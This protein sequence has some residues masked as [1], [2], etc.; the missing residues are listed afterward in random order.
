MEV[1]Q[2]QRQCP[3]GQAGGSCS[4]L[5]IRVPLPPSV[6]RLFRIIFTVPDLM[7]VS[8]DYLLHAFISLQFFLSLSFFSFSFFSS[9]SF[10][11]TFLYL[12]YLSFSFYVVF[13]SVPLAFTLLS[14]SFS[15]FCLFINRS[16]SF[17]R[18]SLHHPYMTQ[19]CNYK[20]SFFSPAWTFSPHPLLASSL[21]H[22]FLTTAGVFASVYIPSQHP[23]EGPPPPSPS[24]LIHGYSH[25]VPPWSKD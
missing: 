22:L 4:S 12:I 8:Q 17:L 3:R 1:P 7:H 19:G 25:E 9:S 24:S 14:I 18:A 11:F 21:A 13:L 23:R 10:F 6:G 16:P 5:C 2:E 15:P 20:G